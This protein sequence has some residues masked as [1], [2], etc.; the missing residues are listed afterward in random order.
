MNK[1]PF[2]WVILGIII[3]VVPTIVYLCFLVPKLNETYNILMTSGGIIST[4]GFYGASKIPETWKS[5]SLFKLAAN[6]FTALITITI[7]QEFLPQL[8]GLVFVIVVSFI[9]FKFCIGR[10]KDGRRKLENRELA[11]QIARSIAET[12]K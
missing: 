8:I 7:V 3:L 9:L 4:S 11:E 5:A 12:S 6:S 1:H 10:Y 2:I